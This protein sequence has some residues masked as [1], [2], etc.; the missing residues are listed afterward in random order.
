MECRLGYGLSY[1]ARDE[2]PIV[3][4]SSEKGP[5]TVLG[6]LVCSTRSKNPLGLCPVC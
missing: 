4:S 2:K 3:L 5:D 1:S 6:V